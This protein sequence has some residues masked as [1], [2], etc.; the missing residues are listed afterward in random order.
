[1]THSSG[2]SYLNS[3]HHELLRKAQRD[4]SEMIPL[5]DAAEECGVDC[6]QYREG[7]AY[8]SGRINDFLRVFFPDQ[9]VPPDGSGLPRN[10][11]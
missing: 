2:Q 3:G 9:V 5:M 7:H 6:Q 1:M 4:L 10:A 11:G 8:I